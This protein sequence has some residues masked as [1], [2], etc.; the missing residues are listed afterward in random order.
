VAKRARCCAGK[1]IIVT[2]FSAT[3]RP[4][5]LT[6]NDAWVMELADVNQ[7]STTTRSAIDGAD[8]RAYGRDMQRAQMKFSQT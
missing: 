8:G 6:L 3:K 5:E 1:T 7:D 4:F 2:I